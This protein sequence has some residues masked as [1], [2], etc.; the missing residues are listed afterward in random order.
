MKNSTFLFL[1]FNWNSPHVRLNSYYEA[2]NYKK[3]KHIKVK[4]YRKPV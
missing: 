1:F 4:E 2:W 3:K